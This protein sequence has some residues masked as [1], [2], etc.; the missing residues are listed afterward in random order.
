MTLKEDISMVKVVGRI[1]SVK[2]IFNGWGQ[3]RSTVLH[4]SGE[5][6]L[7]HFTVSRS[8]GALNKA[9]CFDGVLMNGYAVKH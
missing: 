6:H 4:T 8:N 1:Y 3:G 9:L 7:R 2:T 5:S